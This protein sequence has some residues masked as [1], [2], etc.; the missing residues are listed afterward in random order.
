MG[1]LGLH[2][3]GDLTD[4]A[5]A[6]LFTASYEGYLVPFVVDAQAVR[7]LSD[8]YDL[9]RE[10]SRIAVRDGQRVGLANLG[11]SRARRVD[12]W[13]RRRAGRAP[14]RRRGAP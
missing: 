10:A 2:S 7:F 4:E 3:A 14:P 5:L 6:D 9:D 1:E 13:R 12:R 8:A 11:L